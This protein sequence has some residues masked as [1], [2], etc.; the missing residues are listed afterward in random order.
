MIDASHG[1]SLKDPR[2][3]IDVIADVAGQVSGGER[4]IFGVMVESHLVE[5]RQ[6]LGAGDKLTYGQS[7][8]DACLGW[9]DTIGLLETL[10]D[11]VERRRAGATEPTEPRREGRA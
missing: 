1:N 10:A 9:E 8:T 6:E 3:Q 11:S 5:G 2:R 7:V 4:R